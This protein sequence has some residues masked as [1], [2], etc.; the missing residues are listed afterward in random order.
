VGRGGA[1]GGALSAAR[2]RRLLPTAAPGALAAAVVGAA[3]IVGAGLAPPGARGAEPVAPTREIYQ[4]YRVY[5]ANC[6]RCHGIDAVAGILAPDARRA[7]AALDL[8]EF[9]QIVENGTP[10]KGMPP[11]GRLL[12]PGE[13]SALYAY[14]R[15]RAD[16]TLR[17]GRLEAP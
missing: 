1:R 3:A 16:G 11:F 8:P 4:G 6:Y 15:A 10:G 9:R 17:P 2:R 12:T 5:H 13:V 7:A 14:L